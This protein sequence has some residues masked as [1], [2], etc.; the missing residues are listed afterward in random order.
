M[1]QKGI[2]SPWAMQKTPEAA[3]VEEQLRDRA[4]KGKTPVAMQGR[5]YTLLITLPVAFK[6]GQDADK[7]ARH[8]VGE[9]FQRAQATPLL[10]ILRHQKISWIER[11]IIG[12]KVT[13]EFG[14]I[15]LY[16]AASSSDLALAQAFGI[17]RI[18]LALTEARVRHKA[19]Q[20]LLKEHF[21]E[22]L[23]NV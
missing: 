11:D 23:R 15:K 18:A 22:V 3:P 12:P 14:P 1:S 16:A 2:V 4:R 10:D 7:G 5:H 19:M 17:D 9:F 21:L 20:E 13:F 8:V 6:D